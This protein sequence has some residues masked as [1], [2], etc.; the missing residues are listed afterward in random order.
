M[1]K[2]E[3]SQGDAMVAVSECGPA[4][5]K[6]LGDMLERN[7]RDNWWAMDQ[8]YKGLEAENARLQAELDAALDRLWLIRRRFAEILGDAVDES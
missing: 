1:E 6:V 7:A 5:L 8:A 2:N 3:V 4:A